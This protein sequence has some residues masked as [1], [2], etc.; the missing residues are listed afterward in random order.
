[1]V[2]ESV[3][4]PD[5]PALDRHAGA[6]H[7][8]SVAVLADGEANYAAA[9]VS[10]LAAALATLGVRPEERVLI[11]MPDESGFEE[12]IIGTIQ[13]AAV[14][15][16][17]NPSLSPRDLTTVAGE[18]G[19]RLAVVSGRRAAALEDL[20]TELAVPVDGPQGTWATVLVLS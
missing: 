15:L 11:M 12:A 14:P 20:S 18:A 8:D 16:P 17:V 7:S 13:L 4:N 5:D 3:A 1:M 10:A 2:T 9:A 6:G 19:A